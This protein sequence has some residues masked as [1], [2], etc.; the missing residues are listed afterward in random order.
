M[1][2]CTFS[3]WVEEAF[4]P[5]TEKAQEVARFLLKEIIPWFGIPVSIRSGNGQAFVAEVVKLVG[6][7]LGI[8]CKV[9]MA[10][11]LQSSGK[12]ECKNKTLNLQLEN[13]CQEPHLQWGQLLPI[14]LLRIR[15][16]PTK[17]RVSPLLNS[18]LGTYP[19]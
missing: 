6:N 18:F 7:G 17:R 16:S 13:L 11:C 1:F 5:W 15:S 3:E 4:L 2:V 19:F 12:V 8:T 14:A 9:H 10:Y